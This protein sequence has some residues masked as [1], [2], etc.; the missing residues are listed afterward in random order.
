MKNRWLPFLL[1]V[2]FGNIVVVGVNKAVGWHSGSPTAAEATHTIAILLLG[3]AIAEALNY[4]RPRRG[5][6]KAQAA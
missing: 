4:A 6:Q 5:D 2:A 3:A 1:V